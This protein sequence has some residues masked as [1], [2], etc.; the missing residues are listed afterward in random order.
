[1]KH[2]SRY[3]EWIAGLF[4]GTTIFLSALIGWELHYWLH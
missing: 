3:D 1:M 2:R 4:F